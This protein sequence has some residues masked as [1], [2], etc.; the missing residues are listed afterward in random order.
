METN[1]LWYRIYYPGGGKY[2]W[3]LSFNV[4]NVGQ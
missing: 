2:G 1:G 3:V 4:K